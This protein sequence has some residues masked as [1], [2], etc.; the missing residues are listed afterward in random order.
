LAWSWKRHVTNQP[1]NSRRPGAS[2]EWKPF[3]P[4]T[5]LVVH[6]GNP[7]IGAF[8][9]GV[10]FTLPSAWLRAHST[11]AASTASASRAAVT[12]LAGATNHCAFSSRLKARPRVLKRCASQRLCRFCPQTGHFSVPNLHGH[13]L[14]CFLSLITTKNPLQIIDFVDGITDGA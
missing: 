12:R 6:R 3:I 5:H 14:R 13:F 7:L 9:L 2:F 1:A 4:A 8:N 10:S 11:S